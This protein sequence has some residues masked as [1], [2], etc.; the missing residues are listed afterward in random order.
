MLFKT[1]RSNFLESEVCD[2]DE[3]FEV[4]VPAIKGYD[5][6]LGR[7]STRP[8]AKAVENHLTKLGL[9]F[10]RFDS[11]D[12]DSGFHIYDWKVKNSK[13]WKNGMR[14]FWICSKKYSYN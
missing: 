8:S 1:I 12:L 7:F 10:E 13:T 3:D 6:D 5:Q 11:P 2:S 4:K 14:R 9:N